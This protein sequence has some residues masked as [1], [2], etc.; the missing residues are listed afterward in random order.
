MQVDEM[1]IGKRT[2]RY[3][4][5]FIDSIDTETRFMVSSE[6]TRKRDLKEVKQVLSL[7]KK[8][9]ERQFEIITSDS[10]LAYPKAI[11]KT[12]T[13]KNKSNTKKFGVIHNQVNASKGEG[14]NYKIE[15]LHN[16]VRQRINVC[17]GFHGSVENANTLMKG[18]EG[19]YNF[20]R[21]HQAIGKTPSELATDIKLKGNKW[22]DLIN[23]SSN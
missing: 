3:N 23:L 18:Y 13:L 11:Q 6:F 12:F 10:W 15:R 7:A 19:F 4:G 21:K 22:L 1:E 17:R 20:I 16:S 14:F 8:K 2:S 5:W 9:T